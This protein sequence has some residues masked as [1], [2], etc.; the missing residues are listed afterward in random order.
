V[1]FP[2]WFIWV[3]LGWFGLGWVLFLF[4]VFW[5]FVWFVGLVFVLAF[6]WFLFCPTL[7]FFKI[8]FL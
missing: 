8:L 1:P 6:V 4:L 3:E 5:V 7:I 2:F